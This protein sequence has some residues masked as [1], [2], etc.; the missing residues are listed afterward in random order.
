MKEARQQDVQAFYRMV[1]NL[2]SRTQSPVAT[3][4]SSPTVTLP[5]LSPPV[6]PIASTAVA[7]VIFGTGNPNGVHV[8]VKG[9]FFKDTNSGDLWLKSVNGTAYGWI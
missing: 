8:G 6:A 1:N 3:G 7:P 2:A 5:P 4:V 9:Q